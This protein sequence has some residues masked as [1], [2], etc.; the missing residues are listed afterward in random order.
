MGDGA[1]LAFFDLGDDAAA[2]PSPNTPDWNAEKMMRREA[3][4]QPA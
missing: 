4:R 1:N 3:V 2:A